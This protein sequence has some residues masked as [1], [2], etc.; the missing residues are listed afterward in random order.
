LPTCTALVLAI[1]AVLSSAHPGRRGDGDRHEPPRLDR[2][3]DPL[4]RRA[5]TRIGTV[6]LRHGDYASAVAFAVDGRTLLSAGSDDAVRVWSLESG[7]EERAF[8]AGDVV[9]RT[10]SAD[11]RYFGARTDDGVIPIWDTSTGK[12]VRRLRPVAA[13]VTSVLLSPDGRTVATGGGPLRVWDVATGAERACVGIANGSTWV[14]AAFAPDSQTIATAERPWA[15]QVGRPAPAAPP[16]VFVWDVATG[17]ELHRFRVE[18][19]PVTALAFAPDGRVLATAEADGLLRLRDAST[20]AV[21]RAVG[22]QSGSGACQ[23][24]FSHDGRALAAADEDG[25]TVWDLAS[26]RTRGRVILSHAPHFALSA[27][28]G[29]LAWSSSL[30]SA[31]HLWDVA[32]GKDRFA[33]DAHGGEVKLVGFAADGQGVVTAGVQDGPR[34]WDLATGQPVRTLGTEAGLDY[35]VALSPDGAT[36]ATGDP[37]SVVRTWDVGSGKLRDQGAAGIGAIRRLVFS[38]DGTA[39]AATGTGT[40]RHPLR[41]WEFPSGKRRGGLDEAGSVIAL[42]PG[43]RIVAADPS[44]V[45]QGGT[46]LPAPG[47]VLFWDVPTGTGLDRLND[48]GGDSHHVAFAPDGKAVAC[49][50][51]DG[52]L[53]LL[54]C[55][56]GRVRQGWR[57]KGCAC[58]F[59]P[60]SR[61]VAVGFYDGSIALIDAWGAL[62]AW[63][64]PRL[65]GH[66][67]RISALAFAPDGHRLISGSADATAL[68]W[69]LDGLVPQ[70]AGPELEMASGRREAAWA[71]LADADAAAAYRAMRALHNTPNEAVTLLAERLRPSPPGDERAVRAWIEALGGD[72]AKARAAA[73]EALA[74]R[75]AEAEPALRDAADGHSTQAVRRR[76]RA[77]LADLAD[78]VPPADELR[79]LRAVET[80]EQIGTAEARSVLRALAAG[81][82]AARQTREAR[83]SLER[84]AARP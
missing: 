63:L 26:G 67:G 48:R 37:R 6:R 47:T 33:F 5:L 61:T 71:A 46:Y 69:D 17:E 52:R 53:R 49:L 30:R 43:G 35:P 58:A 19:P 74:A 29:L 83:A 39:F 73:E 15:A 78:R 11:A 25:I 70:A 38:A 56:T 59:S 44:P 60:D 31:V 34:L 45:W 72:D 7:R 32:A 13:A 42:S 18:H 55:S 81:A 76:A 4:P 79:V 54:E 12:P 36:L 1:Y 84:M 24:Q 10:F 16:E 27:D 28:G 82:P 21:L 77:L 51:R 57:C 80:L 62:P 22:R 68:V 2:Y 20:G 14:T 50:G 41:V 3:G 65:T 75:Y 8:Q 40:H 66:R 9:L 64:S 23:V